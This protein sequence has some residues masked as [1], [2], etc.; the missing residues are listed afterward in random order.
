MASDSKRLHAFLPDPTAAPMGRQATES[1]NSK[2]NCVGL[3]CRIPMY[4]M[5]VIAGVHY[6]LARRRPVSVSTHFSGFPG[7]GV[8]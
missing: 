1:E 3:H 5:E 7:A 8:L 2:E 4:K 6:R